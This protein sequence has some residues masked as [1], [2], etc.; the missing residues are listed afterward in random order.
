LHFSPIF[1]SFEFYWDKVAVS[2]E[3]S[4]NFLAGEFFGGNFCGGFLV[5]ICSRLAIFYGNF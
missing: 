5:G 2:L 1:V 4:K 3:G